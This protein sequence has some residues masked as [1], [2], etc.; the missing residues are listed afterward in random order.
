[1]QLSESSVDFVRR[2]PADL[3]SM[4]RAFHDLAHEI[5][6]ERACHVVDF[7]FLREMKQRRDQLLDAMVRLH[8]ASDGAIV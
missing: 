5:E 7:T 1:M 2:A 4:Q 8:C 3:A 6:A